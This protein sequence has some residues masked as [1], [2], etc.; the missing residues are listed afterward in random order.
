MLT[1]S[2]LASYAGVTVRAVRHYHQVGLLPEPERDHSGYRSYDA[3]AVV[4]LIKVRTLAEAGVPLAQV[5]DLLDAT[6]EEFAEAV[7]EIDKR[8]RSEIRRL[9]QNRR[10][11][12]KLAA[13]DSLALP[14]EVVAYLD[15]LRDIG[16]S[17]WMIQLERDAWILIAAQWPEHMPVWMADKR[18][19]F[20]DPRMVKLY[21][22]LDDPAQWPVDDPRVAEIA[23]L[24][25]DM[26]EEWDGVEQP[27]EL[28]DMAIVNLLDSFADQYAPVTD[29]LQELMRERGWSGWTRMKRIS[30]Q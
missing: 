22:L 11:I 27:E 8:L 15:M 21:V 18:E 25:V 7:E 28:D 17:E 4:E 6:P 20:A 13:G 10:E 2:Q 23:D 30:S 29:R 16:V 3:T 19:Q 24:L 12:A 14:D 26:A 5:P 1:I 9:Q